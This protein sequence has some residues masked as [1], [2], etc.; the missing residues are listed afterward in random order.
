MKTGLVEAFDIFGREFSRRLW[1]SLHWYCVIIGEIELW[2]KPCIMQSWSLD[3]KSSLS[4]SSQMAGS[5]N[6][7]WRWHNII[8]MFATLF[9]SALTDKIKWSEAAR[10]FV[11]QLKFVG[12][13]SLFD[14]R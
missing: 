14:A 5:M 10:L 7:D 8:R 2:V 9:T 13:L 12:T 11:D 3:L 1:S 4:I 6:V